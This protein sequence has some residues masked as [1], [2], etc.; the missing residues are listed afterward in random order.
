LAQ[1]LRPRKIFHGCIVFIEKFF[2]KGKDRENNTNFF[3]K[4]EKI[5]NGL[6]PMNSINKS[7]TGHMAASTV[8]GINT[9]IIRRRPNE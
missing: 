9:E 6:Q 3:I 5:G 1:Q 7:C 4:K 8:S 2:A